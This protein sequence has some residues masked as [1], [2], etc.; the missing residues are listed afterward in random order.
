MKQLIIIS[1]ISIFAIKNGI[2]Q[3]FAFLEYPLY[4][5]KVTLIQ[6]IEKYGVNDYNDF[7][8]IRIGKRIHSLVWKYDHKIFKTNSYVLLRDTINSNQFSL[9]QIGLS[10][11]ELL[12]NEKNFKK[13][14]D[15]T[16]KIRKQFEEKYGKPTKD[17]NNKERY[18]DQSK[19]ETV[20]DIIATTWESNNVKLKITFMKGGEHGR[21]RYHLRIHKFQ[22]YLGN[23][24]L[25]E[26]WD[27]Y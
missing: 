21:Y 5:E 1:I 24:K 17:V 11:N 13:L 6:A 18:F 15:E 25:P 19:M 27:G 20:G 2:S 7:E 23:M 3:D 4:A 10:S 8:F 26:W 16:N 9:N 22:D 14:L 12:V